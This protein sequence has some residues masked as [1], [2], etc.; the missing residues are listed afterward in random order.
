M[1]KWCIKFI[2][3]IFIIFHR[4]VISWIDK[5]IDVTSTYFLYQ[6][7]CFH[8]KHMYDE[9]LLLNFDEMI[10]LHLNVFINYFIID[11]NNWLCISLFLKNNEYIKKLYF[12]TLIWGRFGFPVKLSL[13]DVFKLFDLLLLTCELTLVHLL[14]L[15]MYKIFFPCFFIDNINT[16][17]IHFKFVK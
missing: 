15:E 11:T 5:W 9:S 8:C 1:I 12:W 16:I 17:T 14:F 7:N 13:F 2:D 3:R 4:Y 10:F 6:V